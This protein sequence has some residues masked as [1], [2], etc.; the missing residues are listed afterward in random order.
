[1]K[2]L[3]ERFKTLTTAR[4]IVF[5]AIA[6]ILIALLL[7]IT[8]CRLGGGR[9]RMPSGGYAVSVEVAAVERG[10]IRHTVRY[11]GSAEP[12]ESVTV[13]PKVSGILT[14]FPVQIGDRVEM[15]DLIAT[16]DDAEYSQRLDQARANLGLAEARL[17]RSRINLKLAER[18]LERVETMAEEGLTSDQQLDLATTSRDGARADVQLAVA[19]VERARAAFDEARTN[20]EHT[21]IVARM[22]GSVD[23][24]QVDA[25]TL[26]SPATPLCTIVRTDP[27]KVVVNVPES[28]IGLLRVGSDALVTAGAGMINLE[29]RV[30]RVAPT[31]DM[32]TRTMTAE[33]VIPNSDSALRPGMYTDVEL[34]IDEKQDVVLAPQQALVRREGRTELMVIVDGVAQATPV[35]IGI[36]SDG[37]AEVLEGVAPGALVVVRGQYLLNDGDQ[38][39][40]EAP[41]T[42]AAG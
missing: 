23:K 33:I 17:E 11:V 36:V 29:G 10:P 31:V 41:I 16:I 19:D 15:G 37:K 34:L 39:R 6:V 18:E 1:V 30:E 9:G 3:I 26:V 13:F 40:Y 28:E 4:K 12:Y 21:R 27:A 20:F 32:A 8:A 2:A 35:Q 22:S 24:R 38:V 42:E 14:G 25:G 5:L 7:R